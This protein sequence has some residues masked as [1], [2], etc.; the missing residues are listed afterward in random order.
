MGAVGGWVWVSVGYDKCKGCV[1]VVINAGGLVWAVNVQG[2][3]KK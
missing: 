2:L 1:W 3:R